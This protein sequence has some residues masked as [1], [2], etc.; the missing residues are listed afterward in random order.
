MI[1]PYFIVFTFVT[2]GELFCP[3]KKV[4]KERKGKNII[5]SNGE[6]WYWLYSQRDY[7]FHLIRPTY[8]LLS[9]VRAINE[10]T[11]RVWRYF[12]F[13]NRLLNTT[14]STK[15]LYANLPCLSIK[16]LPFGYRK[17]CHFGHDKQIKQN[18]LKIE[19]SFISPDCL[20][21]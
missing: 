1:C 6:V 4:K 9:H 3:K 7:F 2:F 15:T 11:H 18:G 12:F 20:L 14:R 8:C 5:N 19:L 13:L 16:L 21:G 10:W 17:L